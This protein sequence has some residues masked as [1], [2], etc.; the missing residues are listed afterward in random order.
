MMIVVCLHGSFQLPLQPKNIEEHIV[1]IVLLFCVI[2]L[3]AVSPET[4]QSTSA[5]W[6]SGDQWLTTCMGAGC[7][8]LFCWLWIDY[9]ETCTLPSN[10]VWTGITGNVRYV[11]ENCFLCTNEIAI[12]PTGSR[13]V[14]HVSILMWEIELLPELVQNKISTLPPNMIWTCITD[15]NWCLKQNCWL[16]C[17]KYLP[18]ASKCDQNLH[19]M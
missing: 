4:F 14:S 3:N 15:N 13:C 19:H 7:H 12:D 2:Q 9:R 8:Q 17:T 10:R 6:H 1:C 11:R 5:L 16:N 18:T